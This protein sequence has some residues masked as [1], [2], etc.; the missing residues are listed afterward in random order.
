MYSLSFFFLILGMTNKS[1]ITEQGDE[2]LSPD[3]FMDDA[4]GDY[5]VGEHSRS[6]TSTT[7]YCGSLKKTM[8][9]WLVPKENTANKSTETRFTV[10]STSQSERPTN[11]AEVENLLSDSRRLSAASSLNGS[12]VKTQPGRRSSLECEELTLNAM[13]RRSSL[14]KP[15]GSGINHKTV[16]FDLPECPLT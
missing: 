8:T 5:P 12:S 3:V 10:I 16:L 4:F 11:G 6:V 9:R 13:P 2:C 15:D 1:I 14:Q 7:C